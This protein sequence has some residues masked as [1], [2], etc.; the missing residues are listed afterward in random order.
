MTL[1]ANSR[2][3]ASNSGVRSRTHFRSPSCAPPPSKKCKNAEVG[4]VNPSLWPIMAEESH[5][6][7]D[8]ALFGE[9]PTATPPSA[10]PPTGPQ[11]V[12]KMTALGL[13]GHTRWIWG[14]ILLFRVSNSVAPPHPVSLPAP[15]FCP[16]PGWLPVFPSPAPP[17]EGAT[18]AQV[19]NQESVLL[20]A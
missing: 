17:A 9:A 12:G 2:R 6:C 14:H 13:S 10:P 20:A 19:A 15:S 1:R 11:R 3:A 16:N 7:P 5:S 4:A 18:A 8:E